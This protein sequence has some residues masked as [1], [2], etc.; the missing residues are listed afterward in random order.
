DA[1]FR[2]MLKKLAQE[3]RR[4]RVCRIG[5]AGSTN[6]GPWQRALH[7]SGGVIVELV[8]FLRSASPIG[9][10]RLVPQL[11]TPG[12][13]FILAVTLHRVADPLVHEFTPIPVVLGRIRPAGS[14]ILLPPL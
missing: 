9:D 2:A 6:A 11:P 3:R 14:A 7:G 12:E 10:V 4:F 8:V 13:H 5:C 1:H